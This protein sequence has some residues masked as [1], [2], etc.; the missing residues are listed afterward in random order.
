VVIAGGRCWPR[1]RHQ[2]WKANSLRSSDSRNAAPPRPSAV[3]SAEPSDLASPNGVR[4]GACDAVA[5][6]GHFD[7][8]EVDGARRTFA[9]SSPV[10]RGQGGEGHWELL[11]A[12]NADAEIC[13]AAPLSRGMRR[14]LHLIRA[15][16]VS[17]RRRRSARHSW[18][19]C[20]RL[21]NKRAQ[22]QRRRPWSSQKT[23]RATFAGRLGITDCQTGGNYQ[24]G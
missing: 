7:P 5:W 24:Y 9:I 19:R 18:I 8:A 6:Q 20:G 4:W 14:I 22:R 21:K 23:L 12:F 2:H 1:R 3:A 10:D 11:V 17:T 16:K 13:P 15:D